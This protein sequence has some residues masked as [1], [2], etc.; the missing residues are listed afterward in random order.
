MPQFLEE[1]QG[2]V[3]DVTAQVDEAMLQCM[4]GKF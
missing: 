2:H 4:L 3:S 1:L